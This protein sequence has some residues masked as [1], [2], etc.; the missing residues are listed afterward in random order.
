MNDSLQRAYA[1]LV[2]ALRQPRKKAALEEAVKRAVREVRDAIVATGADPDAQWI[3][4]ATF[5]EVMPEVLYVTLESDSDGTVFAMAHEDGIIRL[6]NGQRVGVYR[7]E[8][9]GVV[10]VTVKLL[11]A[12]E[13]VAT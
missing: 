4:R 12:G 2:D 13:K 5:P 11:A 10:E 1:F 7:L 3:R 6:D 8:S 9:T